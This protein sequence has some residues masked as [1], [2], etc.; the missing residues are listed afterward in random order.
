MD[1]DK[2]NDSH[3]GKWLLAKD[4]NFEVGDIVNI[5]IYGDLSYHGI[6]RIVAAPNG[7]QRF[8]ELE[9]YLPVRNEWDTGHKW[10]MIG[11][12]RVRFPA[13]VS[14]TV[15]KTKE[16]CVCKVCKTPNEF[17]EPN[18]PDGGYICYEHR[19]WL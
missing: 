5:D 4:I 7:G 11:N 8:T 12:T 17:A 19:D 15:S 1:L 10:N 9:K 3:W 2:H 16:I 6:F 13:S 18:Q 14:K